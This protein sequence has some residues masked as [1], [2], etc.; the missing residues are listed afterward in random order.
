MINPTRATPHNLRS[1]CALTPTA[2]SHRNLSNLSIRRHFCL[3]DSKPKATKVWMLH[4]QWS[5]HKAMT[6][7]RRNTPLWRS[8]LSRVSA[9]WMNWFMTRWTSSANCKVSSNPN[10][11]GSSRKIQSRKSKQSTLK[12][13]HLCFRDTTKPTSDRSYSSQCSL[14]ATWSSSETS[15]KKRPSWD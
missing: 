5:S 2:D 13:L 6:Y 15:Q 8:Q 11:K 1:K 12:I 14:H 10:W 9:R 7:S 3:N 4:R